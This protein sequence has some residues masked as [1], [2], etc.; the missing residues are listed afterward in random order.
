ME[1]AQ[2]KLVNDSDVTRVVIANASRMECE[3]MV[4]A[5]GR[6]SRLQ[7][8]DCA[9]NYGEVLSAIQTSRPDVAVISARLQDGEFAG[10]KLLRDLRLLH[11]ELRTIV[12]I[13][14]DERDHVILAFRSGARGVFC[15]TGHPKSLRRCIQRVHD[16]QI[17][18]N[19]TQTEYI[20]DALIKSPAPKVMHSKNTVV[21]SKRANQVCQLAAS[22]LSNREISTKLGLSEHTVKNYLSQIF[23]KLGISTRVELVLYTISQAKRPESVK[24][25][26]PIVPTKF[27]S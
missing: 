25:S 1:P 18:A 17:W 5:I 19:S 24:A 3:L 6:N 10:F 8:V 11:P 14:A 23:E 7:V 21:L 20:V 4:D 27:K 9:T 16:G 15:R 2:R 13:D 26:Q 12:V 22:G